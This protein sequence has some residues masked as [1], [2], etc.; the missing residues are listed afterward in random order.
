MKVSVVIPTFN[1]G[2]L[3][4]E[5]VRSI[6]SQ[7]TKVVLEIMIIDSGSKDGSIEQISE[8]IEKKDVFNKII[9]IKQRDFSHGKTRNLAI[10]NT[11]G[12]I[13]ILLTQDAIPLGNT[14]LSNLIAGF[15]SDPQII[16][17]FGRH[18]AHKNHP[19]I[20]HRNIDNHFLIMGQTPIRKI[21]DIDEY[22][23]NE[24]LRQKLH[25]FSNNNSAIRRSEWE[26]IPFPD[27]AYGEDQ[28]WAK[29]VLEKGYKI[30]YCPDAIVNHS[31]SFST[32]KMYQRK[33]TEVS[34]FHR[35]FGYKLVK[36][37]FNTLVCVTKIT[38]NDLNW[39]LKSGYCYKSIIY[40]IRNAF[41]EFTIS[42]Q[43]KLNF[44]KY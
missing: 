43:K 42:I 32:R 36:Q 2:R 13:I 35:Y 29:L 17:V 39:I 23:R 28:T 12:E 15:E 7:Q 31:H 37:P 30:Q 21:D 22:N 1:G 44:F 3:L 20:I 27:V 5:C 11:S 4:L 26:K 10:G 14:W 16:G 24:I 8:L 25:F 34:Y 38:M 19:K 6:L 18:K 33:K 40:V 9:P 41:V